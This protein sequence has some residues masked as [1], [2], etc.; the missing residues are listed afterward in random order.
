MSCNN[1]LCYSGV[2]SG[3]RTKLCCGVLNW[4]TAILLIAL[5]DFISVSIEAYGTSGATLGEVETRLVISLLFNVSMNGE[6]G[7]HLNNSSTTDSLTSGTT[8]YFIYVAGLLLYVLRVLTIF[9]LVLGSQN[10][11]PCNVLLWVFSAPIGWVIFFIMQVVLLSRYYGENNQQSKF[12]TMWNNK[13]LFDLDPISFQT[14]IT[15]W[16]QNTSAFGQPCI[17]IIIISI[18]TFIFTL[19]ATIYVTI[20]YC[21]QRNNQIH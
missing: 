12:W 19:P 8:Y 13:D 2:D 11:R 9:S 7:H 20:F 3:D 18:V 10:Y 21:K 4:K 6:S 16:E 17:N 15:E 1:S 5:G 14:K